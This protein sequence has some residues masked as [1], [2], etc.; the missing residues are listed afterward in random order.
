MLRLNKLSLAL[1][2]GLVTMGVAQA[3][4]SSVDIDKAPRQLS[5]QTDRLIVKY[6]DGSTVVRDPRAVHVLIEVRAGR[7]VRG[8]ARDVQCAG[9][10][11][12]QGQ[13]G[14]GRGGDQA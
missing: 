14:Q 1:A 13:G 12:G 8:E 9:R 5:E 6:K 10:R 7:D 3:G 11:G 4:V 2:L